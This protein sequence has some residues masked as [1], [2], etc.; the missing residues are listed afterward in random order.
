MQK[1]YISGLLLSFLF[2]QVHAQTDTM[3]SARKQVYTL[4]PI[5]DIPIVAVGTAWSLY[6]FTKIYSKGNLTEQQVL[7]LKKSDINKFDRVLMY[8]Y[9]KTYDKASY[10]PFYASM[11]LPLIYFLTSGQTRDDYAK[12]TFLYWEAMSITGLSGTGT[13]YLVDR[14]RP[15][16]YFPETPMDKRI[17]QWTKNSFYSGHVQVV[18][19]STFLIAKIYSDYNPGS[20]VKWVFY[21]SAAALTLG[22][23]YMRIYAG[24]HF[25]S[26][27]L[28]GTTAGALTGIL[29]PYFHKNKLIKNNNI[30]FTPVINNRYQGFNLVYKFLCK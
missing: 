9:S 8:P 16:A 18:A 6:A 15:Y 13:V 24:E 30:G 29:V 1:K 17:L 4:R 12:L 5:V 23:G 20:N 27:V 19:A 10:I 26:D 21:T 3:P 11:P 25:L 22:T 2:M 7:D 14:Y 28:L